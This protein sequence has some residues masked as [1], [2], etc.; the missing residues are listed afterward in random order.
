LSE[1]KNVRLQASGGSEWERVTVF[2]RGRPTREV[3]SGLGTLLNCGWREEQGSVPTHTLVRDLRA[4][5]YETALW[6]ETLERAAAA[7]FRMPSYLS[8]S[9]EEYR[10]QLDA[11]RASKQQPSDPLLRNG[12]LLSLTQPG[13]RAALEFLTTLSPNQRL[14]LLTNRRILI[15]TDTMTPRQQELAKTMAVSIGRDRLRL[16]FHREGEQMEDSIN[17]LGQFGLILHVGGDAMT[18]SVTTYGYSL[19]GATFAGCELPA[20]APAADL[21]PRRGNPYERQS[22]PADYSDLERVPFPPDFKRDLSTSTWGEVLEDLAKY[23]PTSLYSDEFTFIASPIEHD[24]TE[25]PKLAG[26]NLVEALDALCGYY[27]RLWWRE[28]D[29]LFFRSRTWFIE[30]QY[31][32]PPPVLGALRRQLEATGRLDPTGFDLLSKLTREQLQGLNAIAAREIS[33]PD[34][35][36]RNPD[37]YARLS[38]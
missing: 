29:R 15:P 26:K 17:W 34:Q 14:T 25:P 28:G 30:K 16:G 31:E 18:G 1:G 3:M 11:V 38:H 24:R 36:R 20:S 10:S 9:L 27:H 13:S 35:I 37:A 22:R 5:Q 4:K 2:A 32:A 23:L 19:G 6:R 33:D 8:T 12:N 21:L 7:L